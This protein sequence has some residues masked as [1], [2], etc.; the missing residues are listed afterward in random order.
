MRLAD[1]LLPLAWLRPMER[2]R[3]PERMDLGEASEAELRANLTD[4]VQINRRLGGVRALRAHLLPRM[5]ALHARLPDRPLTVLDVGTGA[6]DLP[7]EWVRWARRQGIHVRML[8]LDLHRPHLNLARSVVA[9]YPEILLVQ[10]DARSLPLTPVDFVTCSLTLHH[11]SPDDGVHLLATAARL[12][13]HAVLVS[14]LLRSRATY[15]SFPLIASWMGWSPMTRHDGR[16]S[17]QRAYTLSEVRRLAEQAG[18]AE[19]RV[20][21]HWPGRFCLVWDKAQSA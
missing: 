21:W 20:T 11:L 7:V 10:A 2:S 3:V 15:W 8:A 9:G 6:A 16:L 12:A 1:R 4:L 19:A 14:D 5:R 17:I 13:R 18:L